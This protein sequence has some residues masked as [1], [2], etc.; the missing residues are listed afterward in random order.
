MA[1]KRKSKKESATDEPVSVVSETE[2]MVDMSTSVTDNPEFNVPESVYNLP[3]RRDQFLS[4]ID[5][6]KFIKAVERMVRGSMEYR[7]WVH[8]L[9]NELDIQ[10]CEITHEKD[11][12]CSIE[13]HH[14]PI[15]LFNVCS[16]VLD[17][18][19]EQNEKFSTFDVAQIVISLHFMNKIGFVPLLKSIH[20]KY[21]NGFLLI[22]IEACRGSWRCLLEE[23]VVSPEIQVAVEKLASVTK[24]CV[25]QYWQRNNYA[26]E[27]GKQLVI[28]SKPGGI[29]EDN[30]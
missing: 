28:E 23:F 2:E 12:E 6:K 24:A 7:E 11:T 30:K 20:E 16:L 19:M 17:T 8:Y 5:Y 10:E 14:H 15:S 25:T 13:I 1:E 26:L 18:L 3:L 29:N 21:H 22:P 4:P 9:K 27:N